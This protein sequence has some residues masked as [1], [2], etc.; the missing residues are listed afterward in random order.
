MPFPARSLV[1]DPR[2]DRDC[3]ELF[4]SLERADEVLASVLFDIA[5]GLAAGV[6]VAIHLFAYE[7]AGSYVV[8]LHDD[9]RVAILRSCTAFAESQSCA[10]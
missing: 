10:A 5:C 8:L 2:F 9:G 1:H 3:E 6:C 7:V 4:G